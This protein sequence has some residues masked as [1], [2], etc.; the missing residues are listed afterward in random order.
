MIASPFRGFPLL[1]GTALLSLAA[2]LAGQALLKPQLKRLS[3]RMSQTELWQAYRWSIDPQQRRDASLLLVSKTKGST[4]RH[5]RL[6]A[7]QGWGNSPLAAVALKLQ[8][9]TAESLG[10]KSKAN[11]LWQSLLKRFPNTTTAADA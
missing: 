11:H 10:E 9:Q 4:L 2:S 3:P 7:G 8:A 1:G 5:Q 6:L